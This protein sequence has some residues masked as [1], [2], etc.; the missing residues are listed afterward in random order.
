MEGDGGK[1]PFAHPAAADARELVEI[2][3]QPGKYGEPLF[4]G[5]HIS[6]LR[7]TKSRDACSST[8]RR[9]V[10]LGCLSAIG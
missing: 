10:K 6:R 8:R 1:G 4:G 2:T 5:G 7:H 9:A 3:L